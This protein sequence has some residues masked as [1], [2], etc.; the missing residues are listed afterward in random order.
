M[1]SHELRTPLNAIAGWAQMLQSGTLPPERH[2]RALDVIVRNARLQERLI[3]DI[4]DVSRITSGRLNLELALV[5]PSE[6][7]RMAVEAVRPAADARQVQISTVH[8]GSAPTIHGDSAR[9]QQVVTNL[10]TNAVKFSAV[11]GRVEITVAHDPSSVSIAVR[12]HGRGIAPASLPHLF[13]PFWQAEGGLA[14]STGGLGLGLTI[15][16][17]LAELHGGSIEGSSDGEGRGARF[18]VRLP[19]QAGLAHAPQWGSTSSSSASRHGERDL[20]DVTILII[21]DDPDART[22]LMQLFESSGACVL[23]AAT[24][25]EA[26]ELVRCSRPDVIVSDIGLGGE[27]GRTL[28]RELREKHGAEGIP[29]IALTAYARPQERDLVLAAGF[30]AHVAKPVQVQ[31]LLGVVAALSAGRAIHGEGV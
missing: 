18:V 6:V 19:A 14:R 24:G 3:A 30:D 22:L 7:V 9:L 4:L 21:E 2:E 10:L 26:I 8:E 23:N 11:G 28:L 12:D 29:A 1:V 31:Q 25:A 13:T 20:R 16:R 5:S 17:R 27:D 15:A